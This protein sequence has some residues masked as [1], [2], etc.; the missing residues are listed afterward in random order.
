MACIRAASEKFAVTH[1]DKASGI[2]TFEQG[3]SWR[4]NSW[5]MKVGV[6]VLPIAESQMKVVVHPQAI[7]S[8]ILSN[9]DSKVTA[10]F[11]EAVDRI[12]A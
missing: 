4:T 7:R 10:T 11:F 2:L 5:G 1:S 9:A 12:L 3:M 8:Q 6:T